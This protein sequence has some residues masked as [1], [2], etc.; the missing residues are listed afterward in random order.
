[1]PFPVA[2]SINHENDKYSSVKITS[3]RAGPRD[4]GNF[5]AIFSTQS[6]EDRK[7]FGKL[8][9]A[10]SVSKA[11]LRKKSEPSSPSYHAVLESH[12]ANKTLHLKVKL[13]WNLADGSMT[14]FT[15]TLKTKHHLLPFY[16]GGFDTDKEQRLWQPRDFYDAAH[17][18]E[19][20]ET[21]SAPINNTETT[22][23]LFPF[24]RRA[25]RW[26]L[27]RE[28][29]AIDEMGQVTIAECQPLPDTTEAVAD[30]DG[31]KVYWNIWLNGLAASKS[32]FDDHVTQILRGGILAEEM[33]LGKT[34]EI[35]SLITLHRRPILDTSPVSSLLVSGATLIISP[36]SIIEQWR[37]EIKRH[38]PGLKVL[39]YDGA[40]KKG[41]S[42]S[43]KYM[44]AHDVVLT[45]YTVLSSEVW[46]ARPPPD[47]QLRGGDKR[48]STA[49]RSP[50]TQ[51]YW[52]RVCLDEAQMIE[53]GIS[54]AAEVACLVPRV[55]AWAV[56]GTPL[57]KDINDLGG[58]LL[59]LNCRPQYN[60]W[61]TLTEVHEGNLRKLIGTIALRHT[62]I[63]IGKELQLPHQNRFVISMPFNAIEEENYKTLFKDMCYQLGLDE[64]GAPLRVD[65]DPEDFR[66]ISNMRSWLNRLR[67]TCSHPELGGERS[68]FANTRGGRVLRSVDEVLATMID[69]NEAAI[70]NEERKIVESH[71]IRGQ[72]YENAEQPLLAMEHW[73]Q[74]LDLSATVVGVC[75]VQLADE[76]KL[77]QENGFFELEDNVDEEKEGQEGSE[78]DDL[79]EYGSD[80]RVGVARNRLRL[81]LEMAHAAQ[82]FMG[83]AFFQLKELQ[84]EESED[85][86]SFE[87]K[88]VDAYEKAKV[89]RQEILTSVFKDVR[90]YMDIVGERSRKDR[91]V[92]LP[93]LKLS[94]DTN[95]MEGRMLMDRFEDFCEA[96]NRQ[97]EQYATIRQEMV[98]L[99]T[100]SLIDEKKDD[101]LL[102]DEYEDS[103][104]V[105]DT[106]Y[107]YLEALR[108]MAADRHDALTGQV[109][110]LIAHEM[111]LAYR[112]ALNDKEGAD[113]ETFI[114]LMDIRN[115]FKPQISLGS[116]RSLL[117][118]VRSLA[119]NLEG[120]R[121]NVELA[122]AQRTLA[123]MQKA[124]VEQMKV[125][126]ALTKEIDLLRSTMNTRLEYYRQLQK[127]SDSVEPRAPD[128][129]F[130]Q[131]E[132]N[133]MAKRGDQAEKTK[134]DLTSKRR[135][136]DHLQNE[137]E[138]RTCSICTGDIENG[139]LTKC[140]HKY[141]VECFSE[142]YKSHK[143][144][145]L[146][147]EPIPRKNLKGLNF[148]SY[149][150]KEVS[151]EE[152]TSSGGA[153]QGASNGEVNGHKRMGI[154][155]NVTA[156]TLKEIQNTELSLPDAQHAGLFGASS[157]NEKN[158]V[159][160]F[161]TKVD[162]LVRQILWI[163]RHDAGAK[164]IIFSQYRDF[165]SLI[166]QAFEAYQINFASIDQPGG[167]DTFRSNAHIECFLLHARAHS[168]GLNLTMATH[169]I[170][171]EPLI[172]TAIE[173][174]AI[175]RVHRIG[176][177]RE[178]NVWMYLV[179]G[180]VEEKVY[181]TSVARRMEHLQKSRKDS[182]AVVNGSESSSK[183]EGKGKAKVK[184]STTNLLEESLEN[185]NSLELRDVV[186]K[187]LL[188]KDSSGGGGEMVAQDDLWGCLFGDLQKDEKD[189]GRELMELDDGDMVNGNGNGNED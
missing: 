45:T 6:V 19:D 85:R 37:S 148:I 9:Y 113:P 189:L 60:H 159:R 166:S 178:T 10:T 8:S 173:L 67:R 1:M 89:M 18:T 64:G 35:I 16:L 25:V 93:K 175:A 62:K 169:V 33:G 96:M 155:N 101:E 150:G 48:K 132:F 70:R 94:E 106:M 24:Q 30:A 22:F 174:Q 167:I 115:Q 31:R 118:D 129:K 170:L 128:E 77:A 186:Y 180:T 41:K 61:K 74:C 136:L 71:M 144:C 164:T 83:N 49:P 78:Y 14:K 154:Y 149:V 23:D 12:S 141:C 143:K 131:T 161:S 139:V 124:N 40:K 126:T 130:P 133:D 182:E 157:S 51:I 80:S 152:E 84:P 52:W 119:I 50:L 21:S 47:R 72:M 146:C 82:F 59:F 73:Q 172:N 27:C 122:L 187:D 7:E 17:V 36:P 3:R 54:H 135:Y 110:T 20:T 57:R 103:T 160:S 165:L 188:T 104:K 102:G 68:R 158:K 44:A 99:L 147:K 34:V 168:S 46:F 145:P 43:A 185:A 177:K 28:G 32:A 134:T 108:A 153:R 142:W 120:K 53:S 127:L 184:E 163:R 98:T 179:K 105:Q 116:L 75:R 81:W 162:F 65:W 29:A 2:V 92:H 138:D 183:G 55:N 181:K 42:M 76:I 100:K 95:V 117:A 15:S 176:Q 13:I 58:L 86:L 112:R 123:T 39:R 125:M 63:Q 5:E 114:R 107:V 97:A 87:V 88:E 121:S 137:S 156:E 171:C 151:V 69:Q 90:K 111:D 79:A 11:Y 38:S 26:L 140:G 66:T 109:N 4:S 91:F 56:T